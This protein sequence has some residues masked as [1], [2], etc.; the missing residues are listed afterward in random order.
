MTMRRYVGNK[1][2]ATGAALAIGAGLWMFSRH[3]ARSVFDLVPGDAVSSAILLAAAA[4]LQVC[5]ASQHYSGR[6]AE[7]WNTRAQDDRCLLIAVL[8]TPG[9]GAERQ[10]RMLR[11]P[12]AFHP[13][14]LAFACRH[15]V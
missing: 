1:T 3:A 5:C 8:C 2:G 11:L 4:T 10:N 6:D 15:L 13:T 9:R 14:C 12:G 7:P